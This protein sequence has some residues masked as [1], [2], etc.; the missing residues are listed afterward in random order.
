MEVDMEEQHTCSVL[1]CIRIKWSQRYSIASY[2]KGRAETFSREAK[3]DVF[4]SKKVLTKYV[5]MIL[6]QIRPG[7][8][9]A[10]PLEGPGALL[11]KC[12][13]GVFQIGK[14]PIAAASDS[15]HE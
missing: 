9:T 2:I 11:R 6:G 13:I 7:V 4:L 10:I 3:I 8:I 1:C 12:G 14:C 15:D 5:R